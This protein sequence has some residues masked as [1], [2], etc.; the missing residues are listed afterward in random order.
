MPCYCGCGAMPEDPTEP[1]DCFIN[2]D[3]TFDLTP[4]AAR[5]A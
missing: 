1:A 5:S 3:G 4:A 2:A